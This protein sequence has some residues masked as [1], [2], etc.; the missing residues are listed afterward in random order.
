MVQCVVPQC[1]II[2]T[3]SSN[4]EVKTHTNF[5]LTTREHN[6]K[7]RQT[8]QLQSQPSLNF[9]PSVSTAATYNKHVTFKASLL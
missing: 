9:L 7:V 2:L 1:N 6:S 5:L 3:L 4:V 8:T